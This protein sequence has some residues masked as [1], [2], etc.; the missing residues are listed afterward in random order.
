M[1]SPKLKLVAMLAAL[2]VGACGGSGGTPT[3]G[4]NAT[5]TGGQPT[6]AGGGATTKPGGGT[7]D[8]CAALSPA[9]IK[10]VTGIDY[11]AGEASPY[12]MPSCRWSV[13]KPPY[14][15]VEVEVVTTDSFA[16]FK[17]A[18]PGGTDTTVSGKTAYWIDNSSAET[19]WVD[20]GGSVLKIG[21]SP[22]PADGQVTVKRLAEIAIAKM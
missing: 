18:F 8:P 7:T 16:T 3:S 13:S 20:L 4:P 6:A 9:D 12:G 22:V 17:A 2:V 19:I 14:N 1:R 5:T 11:P 21:I 15:S 10:T